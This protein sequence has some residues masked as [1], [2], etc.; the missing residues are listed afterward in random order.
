M[1]SG[2]ES[3]LNLHSI[4]SP[5]DFSEQSRHAL[6][7]AAAFATRFQSRLTVVSVVDPLLAEAARIRW[8]QDLVLA[9]TEPALRDFVAATWPGGTALSQQIAFRTPIGDPAAGIL[10]TATTEAT[11]L[12]VM[13]TRGLGGL[14]KWLL[15]STTERVLRRTRVPVLAVP[16]ANES[17][18]VPEAGVVSRIVA[19]TDFSESSVAAAKT[20]AQ[21][22]RVFSA[23]LTL[24]HIV[25]P[26][27][28]PT[29]WQPLVEESGEARA[30]SARS[31]LEALSGQTLRSRRVRRRGGHGT[32][33]RADRLH[34]RGAWSAHDRHGPRERPGPVLAAPGI[35]R[36][37]RVVFDR[38]SGARG[39]RSHC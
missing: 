20:A 26:L 21:L 29:Q 22:A 39:A 4:L 12:I 10:E 25:E 27:A 8:H 13:G 23:S 6:R 2:S 30:G 16:L 33:G 38:D 18:A 14:Q 17:H 37:P 7:W 24:T 1:S 28:V 19:A 5:V 34:R 15:G 9:E 3:S 11:D 35:H 31:R 36:V 32:P